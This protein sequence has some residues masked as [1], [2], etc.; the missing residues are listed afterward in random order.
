LLTETRK[1]LGGEFASGDRPVPRD[2]LLA[3]AVSHGYDEDTALLALQDTD[4]VEHAGGD[5]GDLL[6]QRAVE[7]D[8]PSQVPDPADSTA[9]EPESHHSH[10]ARGG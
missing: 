1:Y 10:T 4:A 3:T 2:E 5:P 9:G 7:D 6:V 8:E